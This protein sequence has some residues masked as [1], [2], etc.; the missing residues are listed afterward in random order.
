MIGE[1]PSLLTASVAEISNGAQLETHALDQEARLLTGQV[2]G[3]YGELSQ[4]AIQPGAEDRKATI[5]NDEVAA[6]F[7]R[8]DPQWNAMSLQ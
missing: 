3:A 5:Q 4:L 7:A 1:D 6:A 2:H 8:L